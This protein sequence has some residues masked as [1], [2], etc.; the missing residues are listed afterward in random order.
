MILLWITV[1]LLVGFLSMLLTSA[2]PNKHSVPTLLIG[3]IGALIGGLFS[4]AVTPYSMGDFSIA[5]FACALIS[6][7]ILL[8]GYHEMQPA[9]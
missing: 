2:N 3:C 1:G 6:S 7:S 9:G 5:G 8:F 4:M